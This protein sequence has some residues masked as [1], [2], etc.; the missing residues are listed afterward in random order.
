MLQRLPATARTLPHCGLLLPLA[1]PSAREFQFALSPSIP[2]GF[3]GFARWRW[4]C[5]TCGK[6]TEEI[7]WGFHCRHGCIS[8]RLVWI[9]WVLFCFNFATKLVV[10]ST[11]MPINCK[12]KVGLIGPAARPTCSVPFRPGFCLP[13]VGTEMSMKMTIE[14]QN[15]DHALQFA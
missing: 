9:G 2:H 10:G 11:A 7:G 12:T 1:A 5:I 4:V 8:A 3:A 14:T 13:E 6:W 15:E